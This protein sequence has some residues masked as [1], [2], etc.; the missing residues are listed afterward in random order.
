MM[1]GKA[2]T[3][4]TASGSRMNSSRRARVSAV[5]RWTPAPTH[6][7]APVPSAR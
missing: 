7:G 5:E 1:I 4:K 6:R 3:Q 2:K